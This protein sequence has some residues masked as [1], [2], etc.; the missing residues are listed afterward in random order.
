MNL[1]DANL[2]D[3]I[4]V[5]VGFIFTLFVFSY[6]LGDNPFFKVATS[7]LIGV[8]AGYA[9]VI[10]I[11]NIIFP[12]LI[13]PLFS[14]NRNEMILA[15]VFLIPCALVLTKVSSRLSK[16]GNPVMAFLVGIGAATAVGGA[17]T[18]TIFPQ[19]GKSINILSTQNIINTSIILI[20]SL[21]TLI[22][23]HFGAV[24]DSKSG[25]QTGR[26]F[27]G[28]RMVGQVFI[29]ITFSA[30]FAGVYFASLTALIERLSFIWGT[31][32]DYIGPIF[33]GLI[34]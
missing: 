13:F 28:I 12:Q 30:I 33:S 20:G 3:L 26:I 19:I 16:L 4:G 29:A 7:I 27:T 22:F 1:V 21:A 9:L 17:V 14:D 15:V 23:F 24:K 8:A 2:F 10:T 25:F 32:N 6:I 18:G 11:Y 31:F 34:K 5:F